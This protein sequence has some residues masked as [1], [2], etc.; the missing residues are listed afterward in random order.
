MTLQ[1]LADLTGVSKSM[2]GEIE[3]GASNP[4]I[5]VLWKIS[6]GL[7]ISISDLIHE[8][9]LDYNVVHRTDWRPLRTDAC[10]I[11]MIY[12]CG[13]EQDF[14]VYHMEFQ[15]GAVHG[16]RIHQKGVVEYT[17]VY[18]GTMTIVVD[19]KSYM[20]KA[21]DSF[22]FEGHYEHCYQND[23]TTVTKAYSVIQY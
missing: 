20:L 4:T 5:N 3:R 15:P 23:G 8:Q 21:G 14:E 2:L 9:I 1:D 12:E 6:T 10:K 18:E 13:P 17:M 22:V 19:G 7:H 11:E 16:D